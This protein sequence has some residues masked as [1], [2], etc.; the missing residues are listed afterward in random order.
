M[1]T[2]MDVYLK[3]EQIGTLFV[4]VGLRKGVLGGG[5]M[6]N[7]AQKSY[8]AAYPKIFSGASCLSYVGK[9]TFNIR[10]RNL[11]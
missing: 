6:G 11:I 7:P 4:L 9:H 2:Q 8:V 5:G 10:V 3:K 1:T